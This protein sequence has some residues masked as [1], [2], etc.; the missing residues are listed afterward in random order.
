MIVKILAEEVWREEMAFDINL[1]AITDETVKNRIVELNSKSDCTTN[2]LYELREL[3]VEWG[4]QLPIY[5]ADCKATYLLARISS[6]DISYHD[7]FTTSFRYVKVRPV[8]PMKVDG[9]LVDEVDGFMG[10][11]SALRP[12]TG[13]INAIGYMID[14]LVHF[15]P[16]EYYKYANI[17]RDENGD[18]IITLDENIGFNYTIDLGQDIVRAFQ[19]LLNLRK[20]DK[21]YKFGSYDSRTRDVVVRIK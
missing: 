9:K 5:L 16:E 13:R 20:Y 17:D 12:E 3:C 21:R 4:N 11:F 2:E 15:I 19:M 1:S 18:L 8:T 6:D 10:D 7:D 14:E